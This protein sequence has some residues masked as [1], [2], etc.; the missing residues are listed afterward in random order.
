[1]TTA[2]SI[3]RL[4]SSVLK[5]KTPYEVLFHNL[6]AYNHLKAFGCLAFASN[7]S[8]DGDKFQ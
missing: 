6:H 5:N 8:N 3:N 7:L 1:M 4:L 2:D